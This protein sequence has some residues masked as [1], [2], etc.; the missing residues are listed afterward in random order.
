MGKPCVTTVRDM[1]LTLQGDSYLLSSA[2]TAEYIRPGDVITL[3]GGSGRIYKELPQTQTMSLYND[4]DFQRVLQW[5]DQFRRLRVEAH[6]TST[7]DMCEQVGAARGAGAD[8]I[9]CVSTDD[10]FSSSANRLNLTR[11]I[12]IHRT[13]AEKVTPLQALGALHQQDFSALF[14]CATHRSVVVKLLDCPLGRFLPTTH[15][16]IADMAQHMN[17]PLDQVRQALMATVDRNPDIGLRG[18]RITAFYPEITEMQ[19]QSSSPHTLFNNS[20]RCAVLPQIKYCNPLTVESIS[21]VTFL[22]CVYTT[23]IFHITSRVHC[24]SRS[25]QLSGPRWSCWWRE[26]RWCRASWCPW[27]A[28]RTS[29][30]PSLRSSTRWQDR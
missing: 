13:H 20:A 24:V 23:Y 22:V 17:M 9:G 14:R 7:Q 25:V 30:R 21:I 15:E 1:S 18:C 12:L 16:E 6:I 5:A 2:A 3:D 10:M 27:S 11:T 28:P 19:V 4:P 8:A 29:W 26:W